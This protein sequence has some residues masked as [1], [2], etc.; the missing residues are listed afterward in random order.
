MFFHFS[1]FTSLNSWG[2]RLTCWCPNPGIDVTKLASGGDNAT[3]RKFRTP[4]FIPFPGIRNF[5]KT[6]KIDNP[7]KNMFVH[8][9]T[10]TSLNSWGARLTHTLA[11]G[12]ATTARLLGKLEHLI[13]LPRKRNF[14]KKMSFAAQNM[15][16]M[17]KNMHLIHICKDRSCEIDSRIVGFWYHMCEVA[18]SESRGGR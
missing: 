13:P 2:A 7:K 11:S 9:S 18:T 12:S 14:E 4:S 15:C 3:P 1:T 17:C 5:K 10:F 6:I 16:C 8:V